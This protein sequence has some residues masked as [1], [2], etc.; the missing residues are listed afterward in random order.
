MLA[1]GGDL[2][3]PLYGDREEVVPAKVE[4][5]LVAMS[6]LMALGRADDQAGDTLGVE[7]SMTDPHNAAVERPVWG[8]TKGHEGVEIRAVENGVSVDR[9][10]RY[11][12]DRKAALIGSV[13][14]RTE[15][16]RWCDWLRCCCSHRD[17]S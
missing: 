2:R 15:G 12:D 4:G 17:K 5:V 6:D 9:G 11:A 3:V 10:E 8:D 14:G 16:V 1:H 13:A 7:G